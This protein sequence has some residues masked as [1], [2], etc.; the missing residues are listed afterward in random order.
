M[1]LLQNISL[2]PEYST[3][4]GDIDTV[5]PEKTSFTSPIYLGDESDY[6]PYNYSSKNKTNNVPNYPYPNNYNP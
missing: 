1:Y 4:N 5:Y 6:E 3:V 2:F